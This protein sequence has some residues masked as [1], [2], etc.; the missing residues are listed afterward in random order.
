M[1]IRVDRKWLA[2]RTFRE[3]EAL[4]ALGVDSA[5]LV[6]GSLEIKVSSVGALVTWESSKWVTLEGADL[7]INAARHGRTHND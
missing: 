2:Q 6:E 1:G 4:T 3:S 5:A 7:A